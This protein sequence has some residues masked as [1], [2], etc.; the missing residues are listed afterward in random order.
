MANSIACQSDSVTDTSK[1][2]IASNEEEQPPN[3]AVHQLV[4]IA[5]DHDLAMLPVSPNY[6]KEQSLKGA[7]S[8]PYGYVI[9]RPEGFGQDG[10][11]YPVLIYLHG[12]GSRGNSKNNPNDLN[13]VDKDGAIRAIK[14]GI[15]SPK[16]AMPVIV[17]QTASDWKPSDVK[18]FIEYI[19]A[20]Y[21]QSVNR[22]RIYIAGFSMGGFGTWSYLD[23]YGYDNSLV[24]A[25]VTIAGAGED[26]GRDVG[27][28]KFL[29]F[30][31][32]HGQ[33]DNVVPVSRSIA[34]VTRFRDVNPSQNHQKL[35]RFIQDDIEGQFHRID[36]GIFDRRFW[37][38][39]QT[40]DLFDVDVV[41]WLLHYK[42]EN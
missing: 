15:W 38:V 11:K 3:E 2:E 10:K 30:W 27:S 20:T 39:N 23:H 26:S 5:D 28:L 19:I 16:A 13:K 42:R 12:V 34:L 41:D 6:V 35:T 17:P 40:G 8:S 4:A 1:K 25:A 9:R 31:V 32:F 29:P 24:A 7:N 21:T 33:K 22:S 18:K 14:L 37:D 36:H